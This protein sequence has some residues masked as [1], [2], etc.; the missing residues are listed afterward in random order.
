MQGRGG[1]VR[2]ARRYGMAAYMEEGEPVSCS[3]PT[4]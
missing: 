1:E 2:R 3:I 4:L